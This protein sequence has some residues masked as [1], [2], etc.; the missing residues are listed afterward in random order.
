MRDMFRRTAIFRQNLHRGGVG[1]NLTTHLGSGIWDLGSGISD[2]GSGIWD[3]GSGIWDLVLMIAEIG[4]TPSHLCP[5]LS[6]F[7]LDCQSNCY[8]INLQDNKSTADCSR[9]ERSTVVFTHSSEEEVSLIC[10]SQC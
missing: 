10:C 9:N 6:V 4:R 8:L 5:Y 2:L 7:F 3:L 1:R